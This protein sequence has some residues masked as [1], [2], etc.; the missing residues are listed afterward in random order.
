MSTTQDI[1]L[2]MKQASEVTK[3]ENEKESRETKAEEVLKKVKEYLEENKE[4]ASLDIQS[5]SKHLLFW[6][7]NWEAE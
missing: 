6:I 5:D 2:W 7:E 1:E 3:Q 4:D